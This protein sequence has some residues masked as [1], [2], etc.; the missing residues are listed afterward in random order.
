M[1]LQQKIVLRNVFIIE[2]GD[3]NIKQNIKQQRKVEQGEIH[4]VTF[5]AHKVLH[6]S[7]DT[8]KP[9]WFNQQIEGQ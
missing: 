2:I 6:V 9:K 1:L 3:T 5:V 4:S 7:V 8:K